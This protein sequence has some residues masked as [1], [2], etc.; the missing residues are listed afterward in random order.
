MISK[1]TL[2]AAVVAASEFEEEEELH[3]NFVH[4]KWT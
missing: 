2:I 1:L 3:N 4:R